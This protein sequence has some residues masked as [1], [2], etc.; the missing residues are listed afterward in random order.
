VLFL[1]VA[2]PADAASE[3]VAI[4]SSA[5][6]EQKT[7][8]PFSFDAV[9]FYRDG[10]RV[11]PEIGKRWLTVV[12]NPSDNS[13]ATEFESNNDSF[14]QEKAKAILVSHDRLIEY[15]H[16]PNLAE[17][18]CFFKMRDGLKLEDIA[19]LSSVESG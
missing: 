9:W 15:I 2:I 10:T 5:T 17:D 3:A 1:L 19:S 4:S 11:I 8:A 7:S 13:D 16:D 12:F 18:A 6:S 14:I